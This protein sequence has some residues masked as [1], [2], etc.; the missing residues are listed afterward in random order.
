MNRPNSYFQ[1]HKSQGHRNHRS[2]P[3][4][5]KG[6]NTVMRVRVALHMKE[7]KS[8]F[9]NGGMGRKKVVRRSEDRVLTGQEQVVQMR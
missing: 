7:R 2:G 5:S 1:A 8:K 4:Q 3:I 6:I 9:I